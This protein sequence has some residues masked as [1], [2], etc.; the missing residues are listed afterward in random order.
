MS[1]IQRSTQLKGIERNPERHMWAKGLGERNSIYGI[2]YEAQNNEG[3]TLQR[4][5]ILLLLFCNNMNT[6]SSV[7]RF[8]ILARN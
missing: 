6:R 7:N 3:P 2:N 1:T 5:N 8:E 4:G